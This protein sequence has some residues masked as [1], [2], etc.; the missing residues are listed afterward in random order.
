MTALV[1]VLKKMESDDKIKYGTFY[2]HSEA[3]TIIYESDIDDV[4]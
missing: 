4:F 3:E 2:S 1:L